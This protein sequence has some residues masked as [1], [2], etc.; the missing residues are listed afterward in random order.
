MVRKYRDLGFIYKLY[1]TNTG[2]FYI[3]ST[4]EPSKRWDDHRYNT[5]A[6]YNK[7]YNYKLYR[8]IRETGGWHIWKQQI[9]DSYYE[10]TKEDLKDIEQQY[11]LQLRPTCNSVN[12]KNNK[13]ELY[14]CECGSTILLGRLDRHILTALHKAQTNT[15][16][17]TN[18]FKISV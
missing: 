15:I 17:L 3:G 4:Y 9:I 2:D 13:D 14:N 6:V 10:I 16:K 12:A 1:N 18:F 7:K 11:I 5:G 8:T